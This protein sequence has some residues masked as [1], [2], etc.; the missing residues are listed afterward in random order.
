MELFFAILS[1]E[2]IWFPAAPVYCRLFCVPD[3]PKIVWSHVSYTWPKSTSIYW[4]HLWLKTDHTSGAVPIVRDGPL[5][6]LSAQKKQGLS[7]ATAFTASFSRLTSISYET[8]QSFLQIGPQWIITG[9]H[10][11]A[12]SENG[13]DISD[14]L[15]QVIPVLWTWI[16]DVN[17]CEHGYYCVPCTNR[18]SF[19]FDWEEISRNKV[20]L[21]KISLYSFYFTGL[22]YFCIDN[23]S[24]ARK[25]PSV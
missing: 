11:C 2:E 22:K 16:S 8:S 10:C 25:F 18:T 3:Y 7:Q 13:Y 20:G 4:L 12:K 23:V 9:A 6:Q 17:N 19:S 24:F 15:S 14:K 5:Q 1:P 21:R